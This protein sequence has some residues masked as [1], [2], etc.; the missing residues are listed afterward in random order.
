MVLDGA[1]S[2]A[3]ILKS[4]G[5]WSD[6]AVFSLKDMLGGIILGDRERG[7]VETL[8]P[9]RVVKVRLLV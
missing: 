8:K 3:W 9:V 4:G 5:G 7:G 6:S 1:F 2:N